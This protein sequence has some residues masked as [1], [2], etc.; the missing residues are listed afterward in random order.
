MYNTSQQ[1]MK[2]SFQQGSP[3]HIKLQFTRWESM[4]GEAENQHAPTSLQWGFKSEISLQHSTFF[5]WQS[6]QCSKKLQQ[7]HE[8]DEHTAG[9]T[10]KSYMPRTNLHLFQGWHPAN[11]KTLQQVKEKCLMDLKIGMQKGKENSKASWH[12]DKFLFHKVKLREC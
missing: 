5:C 8:A 10:L 3:R 12:A 6:L 11:L 7:Q 1:C 2:L 4:N 9:C